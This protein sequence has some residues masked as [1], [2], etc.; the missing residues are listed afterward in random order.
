[1]RRFAPLLF[2]QLFCISLVL[3]SF[4][5]SQGQSR[6]VQLQ[7][8]TRDWPRDTLRPETRVES[9]RNSRQALVS[10]NNDIRQLQ[11]VNNTLML[12][13]FEP[14]ANERITNKEIRSSLG[15][16]KKLA[17]RV[18]NSFG[19]PRVKA[20]EEIDVAL[21]VGL[22]QLDRALMSFVRNPLFQ[23]KTYDSEHASQA[24]RDLGEVLR[25]ADMLR[26]LTK[27]N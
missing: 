14:G 15:E 2:A 22:R 18:G 23:S 24:E 21:S 8:K 10:L 6:P 11:V 27:G 25:L 13:V 1:M 26:K 9:D 19:L 3:F 20:K 5:E 12:R 16:I 17:E 4:S 7:V